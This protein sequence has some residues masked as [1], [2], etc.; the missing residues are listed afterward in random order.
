MKHVQIHPDDAAWMLRWL[1]GNVIGVVV[2]FGLMNVVAD[3]PRTL[4]A[5]DSIAAAN[6]LDP[7]GWRRTANGWEHVSTW[8]PPPR[9]LGDWIASQQAREPKWVQRTLAELRETPPLIFAMIQITAIAAVVV[10][11]QRVGK[12]E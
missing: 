7:E 9:P 2:C 12:T 10:F 8:P 3:D 1:R 4:E 11:T 5:R 6:P